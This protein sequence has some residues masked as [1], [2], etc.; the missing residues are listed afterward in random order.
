MIEFSTMVKYK[1]IKVYLILIAFVIVA[2]P[3]CKKDSTPAPLPPIVDPPAPPTG[4]TSLAAVDNDINAFMA[5]YN[6]PGM[7][8]AIT[9]YGKLV[10]AKG[11]GMADK[12]AGES[13]KTNSLFRLASLSKWF[14]SAAIMKLIQEGKLGFNDKV[15]GTSGILGTDYGTPPY[16]PYI[17]DIT[18]EQLLHHTGGGWGNS[19]NDPMFANR[20][21]NV[22]SLLNWLVDNRPLERA[23][24]MAWDYSNIGFSLLSRIIEKKSGQ[25]YDTYVK[26]NILKPCGITAMQIGSSTLSGRKTNEVKYYG[27]GSANAYGYG[28]GVIERL[29]GAGGWIASPTDLMRFLVRVDNFPEVEDILTPAT[30]QIMSSKTTASGNYACG[31]IVSGTGNWYHGGTLTGTRNWMV[32]TTTGYNWAIL[33]NTSAT[34]TE[35]NNDLDKLI[36]PAVNSVTTPWPDV[37]LFK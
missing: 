32:R 2:T 37:D 34:N 30:L 15:F 31:F 28:D 8:V 11:Y 27:L 19:S 12:E 17:T 14:T 20:E 7:S 1:I 33:I 13:V 36:W 21:M 35:F 25:P 22:Y 23:P 4:G 5:K 3:S 6:V 9:R 18:V 26:E 16:G 10:Y 29:D 24:G